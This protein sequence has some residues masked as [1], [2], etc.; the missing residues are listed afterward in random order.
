VMSRTSVLPK[1]VEVYVRG[2][3]TRNTWEGKD[4]Q[5][6]TGLSVSAWPVMPLGQ[7]GRR[8]PKVQ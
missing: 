2:R 1:G 4:R 8:K 7:V 5:Q 3:L 6:R